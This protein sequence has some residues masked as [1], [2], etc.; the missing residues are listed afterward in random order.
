[1]SSRTA[2][3]WMK[4]ALKLAQEAFD[5]G[6]V[7]VGCVFVKNDQIIASGRNRTNELC[8]ATKHAE[9]VAIDQL[10]KEYGT[11]D[12]LL[13]DCD[14]YVNVEPCI[15]CAAALRIIGIRRVFYGCANDR[16]GGN[17]SILD[18][19]N[20]FMNSYP[21]Y[22]IEGGLLKN[23]SISLLRRFYLRENCFAPAPAKKK[24]R[25][26]KDPFLNE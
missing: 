9:I 17:G 6:E 12:N 21:A 14:L 8:N 1:M 2:V 23:E 22:P 5:I 20:S 13:K 3:E 7:P 16:F 19:H 15:M 24:N 4:E 18:V 25:T 26:Y 11:G 10:T